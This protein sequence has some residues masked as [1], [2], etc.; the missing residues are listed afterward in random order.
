MIE[1]NS[2]IINPPQKKK[3]L[4]V[5]LDCLWIGEWLYPLPIVI[6]KRIP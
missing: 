5:F 2:K 4:Q 1:G 6:N 3:I